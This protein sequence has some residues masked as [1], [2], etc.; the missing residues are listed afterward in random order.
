MPGCRVGLPPR[1]ARGPR[2]AVSRFLPV[3]LAV[4]GLTAAP[5]SSSAQDAEKPWRVSVGG[6]AGVLKPDSKL[7]D[8]QWDTSPTLAWGAAAL[9]GTGRFDAGLRLLWFETTQAMQLPGAPPETRV[10]TTSLD[11]VGRYRFASVAGTHLAAAASVGRV[12]LGYDPDRIEV[13]LP[14]SG[15]LEVEFGPI[16][17]WI[18]GGGIAMT[19]SVFPAWDLGLEV[20]YRTYST[21]TAH[22]AGGSIVREREWFGAWGGR[23]GLAWRYGRL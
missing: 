3:L 15:T 4:V 23:L 6:L 18:V 8:Y 14:G 1:P 17:E 21:E 11:L 10:R 9:A 12:H 16:D 5:L 13:V 19:R 20:D 7:A 22:Q 2:P